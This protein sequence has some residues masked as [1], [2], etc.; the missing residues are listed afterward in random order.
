MKLAIIVI[1]DS[2][3]DVFSQPQFV[4][5]VGGFVRAFGDQ[6][7]KKEANDALGAHPQDF[8]AFHIGWYDDASADF[9]FFANR[10]SIARGADYA[11]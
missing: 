5:S 8:E 9:E 11:S 7:R 6:I 4:A 2:A 10:V 3:A 1:R